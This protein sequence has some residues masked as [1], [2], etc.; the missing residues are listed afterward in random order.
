MSPESRPPEPDLLDRVARELRRPVALDD[1]LEARVLGAIAAGRRPAAGWRIAA[2]A[3][4][5]L[6]AAGIAV[7]VGRSAGTPRAVAAA[8]ATQPVRFEL[9]VPASSRVAVV[10]DFNDWDP[11]AS[12]M[13]RAGDHG[14]WSLRMA[15]PPGRYRYTYLVDGTRW[16][17]DPSEP[18][19]V[20]DD[21]DTPTSV[22]TVTG[23]AL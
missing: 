14:A 13:V 20:G 19:T 22:I 11:R 23:G 2:L 18:P 6:I 16:V 7:R 17:P 21:F 10:G 8:P 15:L 12:P 9:V 1:R 5:L 4:G 3:A